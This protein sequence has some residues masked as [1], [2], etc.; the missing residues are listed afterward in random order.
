MYEILF[1]ILLLAII[2]FLFLGLYN[3]T[4]KNKI[5][6]VPKYLGLTI[7]LPV[8]LR[9]NVITAINIK[10]DKILI[11]SNCDISK[12]QEIIL[13]A[14]KNGIYKVEKYKNKK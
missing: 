10:G 14:F 9:K 3:T 7:R 1:V 2:F 6:S 4:R 8:S 5:L 11:K 12:G 13:V